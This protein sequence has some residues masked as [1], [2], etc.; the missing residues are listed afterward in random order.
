MNQRQI[1]KIFYP[2]FATIFH[3]FRSL[4]HYFLESHGLCLKQFLTGY[5][6]LKPF[7][8]PVKQTSKFPPDSE[9]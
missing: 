4:L 6:N 5:L 8:V 9:A 2:V 7:D 1:F 3:F